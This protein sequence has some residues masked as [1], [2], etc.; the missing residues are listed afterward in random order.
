MAADWDVGT[1]DL[2]ELIRYVCV[3][4]CRTC[5]S[6]V[7]SPPIPAIPFIRFVPF[8]SLYKLCFFFYIKFGWYACLFMLILKTI[9]FIKIYGVNRENMHIIIIIIIIKLVKHRYIVLS[10]LL[11]I[12]TCVCTSGVFV[13]ECLY[14]RKVERSLWTHPIP[15]AGWTQDH[16]ENSFLTATSE[17]MSLK[18]RVKPSKH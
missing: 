1:C 13:C 18:L 6:A 17:W 3:V 11:I 12:C 10:Y 9:L 15:A 8:R 4:M 7:S 14:L 5:V 16:S 2:N